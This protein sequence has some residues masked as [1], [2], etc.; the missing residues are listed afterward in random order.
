MGEFLFNIAIG[1]SFLTLTPN[2]GAIKQQVDKSDYI[3]TNI[4]IT[5]KTKIR[6]QLTS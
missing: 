1:K 3:K 5:R 2:I 4:C 6:G